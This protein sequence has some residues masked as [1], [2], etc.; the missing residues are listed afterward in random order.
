MPIRDQKPFA[1]ACA[2]PFL[3]ARFA[4]PQ[5]ALSWS[6][7]HP[8]FSVIREIVWLEVK[9]RDLPP[10]VDAAAL[11]ARRLAEFGAPG[12]LGLMTARDIRRHHWRS[13]RVEEVEAHCV[14]TVG[15][16]NAERVG[17]RRFATPHVG[18]I[19]TLVHVSCALSDGALVEALSIATEARTAAILEARAASG[20]PAY[21]GTGTDCLVVAAPSEGT[22]SDAAGLHTPIGEAIGGA[23]YTATREG[24]EAWDGER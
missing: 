2:P 14:T 22:P 15:L 17:A 24:V 11:L 10:D 1:L 8:G 3:A 23:V 16:M 9:D 4:R 6:L 12:A 5:R 20:G 21:T 7:T 13:R 19:N 18:T